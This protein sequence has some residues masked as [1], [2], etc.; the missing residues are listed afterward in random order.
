M[1]DAGTAPSILIVDADQDSRA[2]YRRSIQRDGWEIVEASDGRDALA[3][4]LARPPMLMITALNL[5]LIDGFALCEILRLDTVTAHVPI[6]AIS[7]RDDSGVRDRAFRSGA[8]AVLV[9]PIASERI[10]SETQR[11]MAETPALR[12][13]AAATRDTVHGRRTQP[14][15]DRGR[16]SKSFS[17]F[18]TTTPPA[19]PP[20]LLCPSC[21][22]PLAYQHSYVGGVSEKHA[23]Q[24]DRYLCSSCGA[25]QYR[26]RTRSLRRVDV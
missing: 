22:T 3:Q 4:A 9:R 12:L 5:P 18:T 17:R 26:H 15:S 25:F 8:D 11:L 23:E 19:Q 7:N 20:Q 1:S 14:A 2:S 24:W 13:G 21:D 6:L 10:A 16:L